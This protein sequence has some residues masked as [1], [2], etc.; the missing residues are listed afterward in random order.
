MGQWSWCRLIEDGEVRRTYKRSSKASSQR[1]R[2][3]DLL[4]ETAEGGATRKEQE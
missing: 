3:Y 4:S 1:E 2:L